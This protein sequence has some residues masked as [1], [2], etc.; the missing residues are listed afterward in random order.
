MCNADNTSVVGLNFT[1][2]ALNDTRLPQSL[3]KLDTL[4][5]LHWAQTGVIGRPGLGQ[6]AA[7][8]R[9]D[10]GRGIWH[11]AP[12]HLCTRNMCL[13]VF[14]LGRAYV[15]W[16]VDERGMSANRRQQQRRQLAGVS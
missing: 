13:P 1:G 15:K 9:V 12:C 14:L 7:R 6:V 16:V 4:Q 2:K 5:E 8:G 3:S 11:C 10:G